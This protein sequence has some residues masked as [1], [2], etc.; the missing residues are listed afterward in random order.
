MRSYRRWVQAAA[1][2]AAA[3]LASY[4]AV[5]KYEPVAPGSSVT[6]Y[7]HSTGH[8]FSGTSPAVKGAFGADRSNVEGTAY[9]DF[10]I[11]VRTLKTGITARDN[12]MYDLFLSDRFP[13]I[14]FHLKRMQAV[15][16]TGTDSFTATASGDLTAHG[17]TKAVAMPVNCTLVGQRLTVKGTA[18][19]KISDFGMEPPGILFIRVSDAVRVSFTVL[20]DPAR[21]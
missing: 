15:R 17:V 1:L 20:A 19:M 9:G 10:R 8:D 12:K 13:D 11:A 21:G 7:A 6:F 18:D 16:W 3:A 2:L 4:A 14:T 5:V